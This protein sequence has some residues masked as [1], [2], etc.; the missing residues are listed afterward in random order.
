MELK[1]LTGLFEKLGARDP[2][3]WAESQIDEGIPQ[4]ARF[5]FLRQAWRAVVAEN[6]SAWI[7]AAIS[8]AESHPAEPYAGVGHA[9]R[10]LRARG[11]TDAEL[12]DLARGMQAQLLFQLCYLLEDPGELEPEVSDVSW[13][14]VQVD[15]DGDVLAN[16]GGLHESVLET[17]PTGREMRPRSPAG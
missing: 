7:G 16:I 9:L 10:S 8:R 3:G 14:L 5:L 2:E 6:D 11:A 15:E 1:E 4:L 17:D 13:S 12:T